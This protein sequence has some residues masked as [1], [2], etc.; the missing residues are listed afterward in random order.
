[1]YQF[2]GGALHMLEHKLNTAPITSHPKEEIP[3]NPEVPSSS[4]PI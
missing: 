1:M 3:T 2:N 4:K